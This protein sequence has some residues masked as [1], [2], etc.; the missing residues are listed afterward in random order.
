[1]DIKVHIMGIAT[2]SVFCF[3]SKIEGIVSPFHAPIV[4]IDVH[5][6]G[7]EKVPHPIF[8]MSHFFSIGH[9]LVVWSP[10]SVGMAQALILNMECLFV[11]CEVWDVSHSFDFTR[12]VMMGHMLQVCVNVINIRGGGGGGQ[13]ALYPYQLG[14]GWHI[15][16]FQPCTERASDQNI[17]RSPRQGFLS[18]RSLQ[19]SLQWQQWVF[20]CSHCG[21]HHGGS[22]TCFVRVWNWGGV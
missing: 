8:S 22:S 21:A 9:E 1:M 17:Q 20:H 16:R 7:H 5:Q 18:L 6:F 19:Q 14:A 12:V 10:D 13:M 2:N 3:F 15:L 11:S 4:F